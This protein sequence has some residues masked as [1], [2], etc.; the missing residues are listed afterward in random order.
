[1]KRKISILAFCLVGFLGVGLGSVYADLT[2]NPGE[3]YVLA[4]GETLDVGGS[5]TIAPTG[6]LDASA[7]GTTII[8]SGD[9]DNGG[10]FIAGDGTVIFND[11]GQ[12]STIT[13]VTTFNN[14][15][16][17]TASKQLVFEAGVIQTISG[18]LNFN[19]QVLGTEIVLVSDNPGTRFTLDVTGGNQT[20]NFVNV[21]DSNASSNNIV[22]ANSLNTINNDDGEAAPHWVFNAPIIITSPRTGEDVG[23]TP[24]VIGYTSAPNTAFTIEGD[25]GGG[26][27]VVANG[28]SD[29]NGNFRVE[30]NAATPL[31]LGANALT[32]YVGVIAGAGTNVNVVAVPSNAQV[33]TIDNYIANEKITSNPFTVSGYA[34]PNVEVR[35]DA[36]DQNGDLLMNCATT[37]SHAVTGAYSLACDSVALGLKS[38][39]NTLSVTSRDGGGNITTSALLDVVFID[40]FGI[41]FDSAS[42]NPIGGAE[43]SLFYDDDPGPGRTWILARPGIE[44]APADINPQTTAADGFY[45]FNAIPGDY[46][47]SITAEAYTYPSTRSS[48]P[49]GRTVIGGSKGEI[50]TILGVPLE[51]DHPMDASGGLV[52][53]EK[54]A[55]K[56]EVVVGDIVTYTVDIENIS[57]SDLNGVFIEDMIPPGFKYIGGKAI[58]DGVPISDP[59]GAR[60]LSF[61]IGQVNNGET[62]ILKYQLIV[63]S[64]VTFGDY[65]N[66]AHA[67]Y[68]DGTVISNYATETVKVVPD[69]IFDMGTVIGKVFYDENENGIQDAGEVSVGNVT[70]ATE[71]GTLITT[72]EYG[73]Y[74]LAAVMPG[75]HLLRLD[76]RTLPD[77]AYLT[78]D[79]VVAIDVTAGIL[80]KVN[81][82]VK[83][84]QGMI[85]EWAPFTVTQQRDIPQGRLNVALFNRELI[86]RD[87]KL[88]ESALFNIFTNYSAF[89]K[90]WTLEIL[91]S[92][93]KRIVRVFTGATDT[94]FEP[95]VWDG[96]GSDGRLI[97][98]DRH[99]RY[100]VR[101][102]GI[103][104]KEDLTRSR[105]LS[106]REWNDDDSRDAFLENEKEKQDQEEYE[107]WLIQQNNENILAQQNIRIEGETIKVASSQ[108][109]V[110]S[111][112]I[113]KAGQLYAVVPGMNKPEVTG[114]DVLTTPDIDVSR[115]EPV[116]IILPRGE[117]DVQI[118][119]DESQGH[120]MSFTTGQVRHTSDYTEYKTSGDYRL[121]TDDARRTTHDGTY[122]KHLK[123]GDDYLFFVA[124]GDTKMGYTFKRGNIESVQQDDTFQKGFWQEGKLAYYLKGKIKGKY[125]IT[126]SF[127][128]ERQKKELFR[129]LDPDKYYPLYGDGSSVSYDSTNTQGMLYLLIEWDKS[130]LVWGNYETAFTDTEFSQFSRT[131]Y[132]A[133]VHLETISTNEYGEP[134]T[135]FVVFKARAQQRGAHNEFA[136]TGGSLFYL[137]HKDVIEGSEKVKIE[138]RDKITGLVVASEEM[139]EGVD[140]EID[141]SQGRIIFWQPVSFIAESTS[142]ISGDL[143]DGNPIYVTVDYEYEAEDKYDEGTAGVRVQKTVGD[144]LVVG[145]TYVSEE[146]MRENYQL[147]GA[148]IIIHLDKNSRI[149]AEYAETKSE[150]VGSF[151]STDGGLSFTELPTDEYSEGKAYSIKGETYLFDRLG[152]SGYYQWVGRNFSTSAT[153]S[154]QGKELIGFGATYDLSAQTRLSL[155]HDIQQLIE[156]GNDQTQL[157]VGATRTETTT[158]GIT[159]AGEKLTLTG[160]YRHQEVQERKEEFESE[161]NREEDTV[162][163]KAEY[164]VNE[165]VDVSLEH[166]ATLKGSPNHQT[167]V[168]VVSRLWQWLTMK[169]KETIGTQGTSTGIGMTAQKGEDLAISTDYTVTNYNGTGTGEEASVSASTKVDEKTKVHTTYAVSDSPGEGKTTSVAMGSTRT[170]NDEIEVTTERTYATSQDTTTQSST[171]G[172]TR[173]R[174]GKKMEGTFTRQYSENADS[175]SNSNIF[176]LSG[177]INDRWAAQGSFERGIVQNHD[178]TQ[179]TRHAISLGVGF[180]DK[181]P[182]S[183]TADLKASSKLELRFDHGDEN[184]R[185]YLF[186]NSMEGK[187][188]SDTT[189]F[190]KANLSQTKNTTTD[191]V[192]AQFKEFSLGAAYRPIDVDWLNLLCKYTYLE[193]DSPSSQSDNADVEK[194]K[195]HVFATEAVVDLNEKWQVTE[196][197]AYKI[198][199]E[200]VTGFDF[201]KSSTWLWVNRVGYNIDDNWQVAGEYRLLTQTQAKDSRQGILLEVTR[202]IGDYVQVG[203]GYN[204]TDFNDD[205]THLDYQAQGPFIRITGMLYDR[206]HAEIVRSKEKAER[207]RRV[208]EFKKRLN[209]YVNSDSPDSQRVRQLYREAEEAYCAGD[210]SAAKEKYEEALRIIYTIELRHQAEFEQ[211]I[212]PDQYNR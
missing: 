159:H 100:R 206:T 184:S 85:N 110:T 81:F 73:R 185:Q 10:N 69:P 68:A 173:E 172:I 97:R 180:I 161:T 31:D 154:Q 87:G 116:E 40:P 17:I 133:K 107:R 205:L 25:S 168:G 8:V 182:D 75:R 149:T 83:S 95:I 51:I 174:D 39:T 104:G 35:L 140:Y 177:D 38:G 105:D 3:N 181:D 71:E 89:I 125:L 169:V 207:T 109:P 193:D 42:N 45:S 209:E 124:M 99:Y 128:T 80:R 98:S 11:N 130:S 118:S 65:E 191:S 146:Q 165:K 84:P 162:A 112:K 187:I 37:T 156:D 201:T 44:I 101:V 163:V 66:R 28:V 210:L 192:S 155:A 18:T 200:K 16:C 176:G 74:H 117:Y 196:K 19:G 64:G 122:S 144:H 151:I 15:T 211:G 160:E 147:Q 203:A 12:V 175:I 62:R 36:L 135:K 194:E 102:T 67:D 76:E 152:L 41:V 129:S 136:G 20:V 106:V 88:D 43:V 150:V 142:L 13:G 208:A 27:I 148:D 166:Q 22:A 183:S 171:F 204:F 167:T 50:F 58:L 55:N 121:G 138:V 52:K 33:P 120:P 34:A 30:V 86:I 127:D 202:K 113:L 96:K 111:I 5:L 6:T 92:D 26:T 7:V 145:G 79:K 137:K 197:F 47:I 126:S 212:E 189:V 59:Q 57:G 46:Y 199:E 186:Y 2:I 94:I 190:L 164:K 139:K 1:M 103:D 170:L 9:W 114:Q 82:G 4:A 108:L 188:N 123:V 24:A 78:T 60:P 153:T 90:T 178:G 48:F 91:D 157:Q 143:T 56:S 158:V 93:T 77:G 119:S 14:L 132:G 115:A 23:Q 61:H 21:S 63:G 141:H 32:P 70:I 195:G 49:A 54:D 134:D 53:I 179:A 72:D 29:N 198:S 131:L